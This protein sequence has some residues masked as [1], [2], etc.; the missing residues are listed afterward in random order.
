[1]PGMETPEPVRPSRHS[2]G[3][4]WLARLILAALLLPPTGHFVYTRWTARPARLSAAGLNRLEIAGIY[5]PTGDDASEDLLAAIT[6]MPLLPAIA[7]PTTAPAGFSWVHEQEYREKGRRIPPSSFT[8]PRSLDMSIAVEGDWNPKGRYLLGHAVAYLQQPSCDAAL[9]QLVLISPRPFSC[10]YD[11]TECPDASQIRQVVRCLVARARLEMNEGNCRAAFRDLDACFHLAAGLEAGSTVLNLM[12]G[13]AI[14]CLAAREIELLARELPL[15]PEQADR[16][17][18]ILR[19]H[20]YE[21]RE[22]WTHALPGEL[23]FLLLDVDMN[24]TGQRGGDGFYVPRDIGVA[25]AS[26][27]SGYLNLFSPFYD[28]RPQMEAYSR[29]IL[30]EA[31]TLIDSP[32]AAPRPRSPTLPP[33]AREWFV[34]RVRAC[35]FCWQTRAFQDAAAVAVA[36]SVWHQEHGTYPQRLEQLSEVWQKLLLSREEAPDRLSHVRYSPETG[37]LEVT[38]FGRILGGDRPDPFGEAI[39]VESANAPR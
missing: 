28:S 3:R 22:A 7:Q 25:E 5:P 8:V 21:P 38:C 34:S 1:M 24:Y 15:S 16:L 14:R 13:Q 20:L 39:L 4:R 2:G 32:T 19:R 12:V 10:S 17:G 27:L 30:S 35:E 11:R 29:A 37:A 6:A 18:E 33:F 26:P 23:G 9:D 36:L 31:R